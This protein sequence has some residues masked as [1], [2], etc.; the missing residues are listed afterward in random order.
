[1]GAPP[2]SQTVCIAIGIGRPLFFLRSDSHSAGL[3]KASSGARA[4]RELKYGD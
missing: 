3:E 1:M 4:L 2:A